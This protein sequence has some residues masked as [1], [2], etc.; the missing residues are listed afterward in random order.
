MRRTP[1]DLGGDALAAQDELAGDEQSVTL[2]LLAG[3]R[4]AATLEFQTTLDGEA[5]PG[6]YL[7][8]VVV[9]D[10]ET[11]VETEP[12]PGLLRLR[13]PAANLLA[14]LPAMYTQEP[15]R[16]DRRYAPYE[17]PAFFERFLRGFEDAGE[18]LR[19]MVSSLYRYLD[20]DSA[21]ADFLPWLATWVALDLDEHWLQLKRRRLIKEAIW[22][23]RWRGT[24]KGLSRYLEI[25]TGV[26]PEIND[27][28]FL[29]MRLGAGTLLGQ[30]TTLGG[31][32]PHTFVVTL[33][34]PDPSVVSEETVRLIIESQ[35]PA[36][37]AYD[38]R[39]VEREAGLAAL[40][41]PELVLAD[42][43][44]PAE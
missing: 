15:P 9:T 25:Y 12:K 44:A 37:T 36:H 21:P 17:D 40:E 1:Q 35:K 42:E 16:P 6:D 23:Y 10:V 28:P 30:D 41:E 5:Y 27:Q 24:R 39:I 22:L 18:P 29:G 13:H 11:G 33:A 38:L 4:R 20:A 2:L 26:K 3:E 7:F 8:D 43:T 14:N 31:V 19:D 34:V 32:G